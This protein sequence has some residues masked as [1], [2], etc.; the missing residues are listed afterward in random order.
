MTSK[1]ELVPFSFST[2]IQTCNE[3]FYVRAD[4]R[5]GTQEWISALR[6]AAVSITKYLS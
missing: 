2:E 4:T 6:K 1:L 3:R 5:E